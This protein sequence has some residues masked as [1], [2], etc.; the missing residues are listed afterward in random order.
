M[1][2]GLK[3]W[4]WSQLK[5]N[6]L[7]Q[8]TF[9]SERRCPC[10]RRWTCPTWKYHSEFPELS[11]EA[12]RHPHDLQT[13]NWSYIVDSSSYHLHTNTFVLVVFWV[14][15]PDN[16]HLAEGKQ[17]LSC[18]LETKP[19]QTLPELWLLWY[20]YCL[21]ATWTFPNHWNSSTG[22]DDW[23]QDTHGTCTVTYLS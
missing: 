15:W 1:L 9:E 3:K 16:S 8:I 12:E 14:S 13:L 17:D 21:E 18:L 4:H 22:M 19:V 20:L 10:W 23:Q 2:S 11:L 5:L 6:L 7:W